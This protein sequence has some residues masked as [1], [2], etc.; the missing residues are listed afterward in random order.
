MGG[1]YEKWLPLRF[2][3]VQTRVLSE[4][5]VGQEGKGLRSDGGEGEFGTAGL[6]DAFGYAEVQRQGSNVLVRR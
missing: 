1:T 5:Q 6:D 3:R 4:N 2:R